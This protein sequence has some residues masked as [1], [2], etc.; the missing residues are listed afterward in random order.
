[1]AKKNEPLTWRVHD[2]TRATAYL[3][4]RDPE[5]PD[6]PVYG[7][8]PSD[9]AVVRAIRDLKSR[10][11]DVVLYPFVLMD[12]PPGNSLPNPYGGTGQAAFPWR[13]R[14]TCHPAAGV[15]GTVD[16]TAAAGTQVA[17]FFGTAAASNIA[18]S[19]DVQTN[20]VSASYSGPNEWRF[21]RFV[22]HYAKLCAAVNAI[23]AGAVKGFVVGSELRGLTTIRSSASTYPAVTALATL[24]ADCR[25][26]LGSGVKLTY[27]ADWSEYRGHDPADGTGDFFFHLDPL[28]ASSAIDAVGIDNY[29]PLSDWREGD[30]HLDAASA[31]S[32]YD[33]D[34]L[35]ANIEGGEGYGWFYASQ[36]NRDA[37]VRTPITDGAYGKPWVFRPKD[38]RAWWLN[39]HFN[40]PGG[41]QSGSATAWVPQSKPIWF[42]EV[43]FPSAEKATNQPNVFVDSKSAESAWPYYSARHRDDVIQRRG[44]EVL[45]SYWHPGAGNN[46]V[47]S[48]Y[49]GRMLDLDRSFLWTWDARPYPAWPSLGD[50][51]GDGDN[52]PFGHWV[53]G[54]FGVVELSA[55]VGRGRHDG[56]HAAPRR[57]AER[58]QQASMRSGLLRRKA[59]P[60]T[61]T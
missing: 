16:K 9:Q 10:G 17:S 61:G 27:A 52:Y 13:G 21:R 58:R 6:R 55:L 2:R 51:W 3:V 49:G 7:G 47:S 33:L 39:L 56:I 59:T 23:D 38:F 50:V 40:R 14:I 4:S 18:V 36:A 28:W 5:H 35:R 57:G 41:V 44:I 12:V 48:V 22:L 43:G 24:V 34:Y 46:P 53:Q 31:K 25:S 15:S 20:E 45:L 8:T 30:S 54:K 26:V 42:T 60:P 11:Y 29:M 1:M 19:V 32:I 37:Q